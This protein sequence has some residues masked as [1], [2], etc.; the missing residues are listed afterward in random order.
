[1]DRKCMDLFPQEKVCTCLHMYGSQLA[2]DLRLF[3]H[4]SWV[5]G[6]AQ[7]AHLNL[8]TSMTTG[9]VVLRAGVLDWVVGENAWARTRGGAETSDVLWLMFVL[10]LEHWHQE[11]PI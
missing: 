11:I 2:T 7:A 3:L 8:C 6:T 5:D 9:G 4:R 10:T 1:M